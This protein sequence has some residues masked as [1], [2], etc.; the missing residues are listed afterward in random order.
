MGIIFSLLGNAGVIEKANY[1]R[2]MESFKYPRK[3]SRHDLEYS[4]TG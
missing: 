3:I 2:N 4:I 1:W